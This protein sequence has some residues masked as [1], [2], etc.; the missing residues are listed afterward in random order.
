MYLSSYSVVI[1]AFLTIPLSILVHGE[2]EAEQKP[3]IKRV[4]LINRNPSITLGEFHRYLLFEHSKKVKSI[5]ATKKYVRRY[6][7]S[8]T[9]MIEYIKGNPPYDAVIEIWFDSVN[10]SD[11]FFSDPDC[12]NVLHTDTMVFVDSNSSFSMLTHEVVIIWKHPISERL[13]ENDNTGQKRF[14]CR[15]MT[16]LQL[17]HHDYLLLFFSILI[18]VSG[19]T[20]GGEVHKK[21]I[22]RLNHFRLLCL[23]CRENFNDS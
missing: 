13:W 23:E 16:I 15:P 2:R 10:D 6:T 11:K 1:T 19:H 20:K 17:T 12:L 4:L 18:P 3:A 5:P 22:W 9:L 21:L 14:F 8:Y 7:Q